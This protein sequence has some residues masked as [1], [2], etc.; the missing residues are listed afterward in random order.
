MLEL[1][2]EVRRDACS[3]FKIVKKARVDSAVANSFVR[4]LI[5]EAQLQKSL[6]LLNGGT[7]PSDAELPAAKDTTTRHTR[8][9]CIEQKFQALTEFVTKIERTEILSTL[10]IP[11][12]APFLAELADASDSGVMTERLHTSTVFPFLRAIGT[13]MAL[14]GKFNPASK[15]KTAAAAAQ[16]AAKTVSVTS[17]PPSDPQ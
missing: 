4:E 9:E 12:V 3:K 15:H 8:T 5:G 11:H 7:L 1:A 6:Q 2:R 10:L 17:F 14:G 16:A 13:G